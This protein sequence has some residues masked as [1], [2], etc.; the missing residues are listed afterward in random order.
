RNVGWVALIGLALLVLT[1]GLLAS[2]R[3]AVIGA[4]VVPVTLVLA[5]YVLYLPG[6]TFTKITLLGLAAAVWGVIHDG[7]THLDA[8][9]GRIAERPTAGGA[10]PVNATIRAASA[11]VR[12]PLVFAVL[13]ILLATLPFLFLGTVVTAFSRPLV[14][15]FALAV[16]AS[17][18]VA[19]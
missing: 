6:S 14:L 13:A 15:T 11:A 8:P 3:T 12:G 5:A 4:V 2:W 19:F 1:L 9:R 7:V 17:M 10:E 18:V 16:L